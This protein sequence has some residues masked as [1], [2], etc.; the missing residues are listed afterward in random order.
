MAS[1]KGLFTELLRL[2]NYEDEVQ[3]FMETNRW[4]R[5]EEHVEPFSNRWSQPHASTPDLSSLIRLKRML[6]NEEHALVVTDVE[7][8]NLYGLVHSVCVELVRKRVV[9]L[10]QGNIKVEEAVALLICIPTLNKY[11][12][13]VCD[14]ISV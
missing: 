11:Y 2:C 6:S 10:E 12:T 5:Y 7:V 14:L 8:D 1:N 3:E 9:D 13:A 4:I